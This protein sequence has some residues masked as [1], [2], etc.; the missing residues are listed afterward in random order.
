[1][2]SVEPWSWNKGEEELTP[3]SSWTCIGHRQE[4]ICCVLYISG[5]FPVESVTWVS[6]AT[7]LWTPALSHETCDDSVEFQVVEKT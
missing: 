6:T 4:S 7:A 5:V 1:M 3:V 2:F